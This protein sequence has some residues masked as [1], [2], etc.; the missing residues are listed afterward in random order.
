M[1]SN[2]LYEWVECKELQVFMVLFFCK[3]PS[4]EALFQGPVRDMV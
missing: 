3:L 4:L 2:N 1:Q